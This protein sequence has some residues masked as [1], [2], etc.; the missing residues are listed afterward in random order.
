MA[1]SKRKVPSHR[2]CGAVEVHQRLLEQHP[3]FRIARGK[4]LA[5]TEQ[6]IRMGR[7]MPA[8]RSGPIVIPVVVHVVCNKAAGN[9]SAAQVN[10]QIA[11]LNR[12][13]QAK[14]S[15][16]KNVP[17]VWAG[18]VTDAKITFELAKQDPKGNSTDGIT[19]TKTTE[20]SFGT[21][22]AVKFSKSGG[23]DAWPTQTYLN[24]WVCDLG[25]GLLGYAQF[26]GGPADTDGVVILNT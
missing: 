10:S 16:K 3:E 6:L 25:G 22:D 24:I 17:A 19:R 1:K 2:M 23:I 26:L 7:V 5:A 21:D 13:Y 18:L 9:I 14:N 8:A 15:D 11:T 4:I 20:T 12:D